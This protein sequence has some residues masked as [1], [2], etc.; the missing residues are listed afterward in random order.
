MTNM[1]QTMKRILYSLCLLWL[2][3]TTA[4]AYDFMKDG[5]YYNILSDSELTCEVTYRDNYYYSGSIV[6]PASVEYDGNTYSVTSI[7]YEA[8]FYCDALTSIDIPNSVT[9][10][11]M[12]AFR[13][14]GG[15]TSISIPNSVT[16]IGHSAFEDCDLTDLRIED[17][18]TS[19]TFGGGVFDD[20]PLSTVYIGRNWD[21]YSDPVPVPD[22]PFS[23]ERNIS[24]TLS[25]FVTRIGDYAFSGCRGLTSINIPSSVTSI[26]NS[27]FY[28]C[29]ALTSI[30]IPNSV[31]SIGSSAFY[32]CDALTSINI[33]SSV[34]SIGNSAFYNCSALT[35]IN[36]PNSVTSIGSSAFYNCDALTSINIPNSVTSIGDGAFYDCDGLT[37]IDIPNSVTSIGSDAFYGCDGLT[38]VNIP[39]SVTSIGDGAFYDCYKLTSINIPNSV[40]SIG[41]EAFYGCYRLTAINI[42]NSVTS[43]GSGA[44]YN[45]SALTSINIPNSV[46]SIGDEAFYDCT[47]LYSVTIGTGVLSIGTDAFSYDYYGPT[48]AI[49]IEKV[50]W[51][52]NTPPSGYKNIEGTYNY[53]SNDAYSGLQNVTVYPYLSSLFEVGGIKYVPISPSERTCAAIDCAYD[54]TKEIRI[55]KTVNYQGIELSLLDIRPA[56]CYGNDSIETLH[57]EGYAGSIV[58]ETFYDCT[59]LK[60]AT[61][62]DV[63]DI[64]SSAF[65]NCRN[66]ETATLT[67]VTGI[68]EEAFYNCKK[69]SGI[70]L[71]NTVT[72]LGASCFE[73]CAALGYAEIG[74]GIRELPDAC[75]SGCADLTDMVIPATVERIADGVFRGCTSLAYVTLCDRD[76]TLAL[77]SNGSEPLFAD[78]P[79]NTVYIGG[80]ITYPTSSSKGYSPF[81]RNTS[82]ETVQITDKETE[83]S[84]NEFYGCTNLKNVTLGNGIEQI[85]NYAFSGCASLD[86]FTFGTN[87]KSIGEEAFSDC[88]AM[89]SLT[90]HTMVP[91]VCGTQ[92]LDDINKWNCKL[93]VPD[94][95]I[96][97]Y[98]Q[99]DQWKEFF[100]LESVGM[101]EHWADTAADELSRILEGPV[102]VYSLSGALLKQMENAASVSEALSGLERGIYILQGNGLSRKVTL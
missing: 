64:G 41:D 47:G 89:T 72:S 87:M 42:P 9:S 8:F 73:G 76:S 65:Y 96:P 71:P 31:T 90:S 75:F 39:N 25:D 70:A 40:T 59:N 80:D 2:L 6:I 53:V 91:P 43:I 49:D 81:Y 14:C 98:Q 27:A 17:G 86:N 67:D 82:L 32:N 7:G 51:L 36:I 44:F 26:G 92:A 11:G 57:I 100:F 46:T 97:N 60:T 66:L 22:P 38:S 74:S 78:C 3:A 20:T 61:L 12:G 99:A 21:C 16:S 10:I 69:L 15:F 5:I 85:G 52:P 58:E 79:L 54:G 24:F 34:T 28:N 93:F 94:E 83:I 1:I 55:G 84:V 95:A 56:L 18:N 29:S 88:T 23:G 45:C 102:Q 19:L 62:K 4:S 48:Y 33:P 13:W 35:S 77:G 37:T 101:D 50:I 63:T 68:G 30:N